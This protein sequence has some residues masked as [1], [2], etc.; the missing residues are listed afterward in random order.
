MGLAKYQ[1]DFKLFLEGVKIDVWEGASLQTMV[2]NGSSAEFSI[3]DDGTLFSSFVPGLRVAFFM[4]RQPYMPDFKDEDD[5]VL[6]FEGECQRISRRSAQG[7]GGKV[8]VFSCN[9]WSFYSRQANYYLYDVVS[10][11]AAKPDAGRR[12]IEADS[13]IGTESK[14]ETPGAVVSRTSQRAQEGAKQI[15]SNNLTREL[16]T[17]AGYRRSLFKLLTRNGKPVKDIFSKRGSGTQ[18]ELTGVEEMLETFMYYFAY[19]GDPSEGGIISGTGEDQRIYRNIFE[20]IRMRKKVFSVSDGQVGNIAAGRAYTNKQEAAKGDNWAQFALENFFHSVGHHGSFFDL[21]GYFLQEG[22]YLFVENLGPPPTSLNGE[23]GINILTFKPDMFFIAPPQCNVI[24][25]MDIVAVQ[26]SRNYGAEPTFGGYLL[27][28]YKSIPEQVGG[29]VE[30]IGNLQYNRSRAIEYGEIDNQV[31]RIRVSVNAS[32]DP[33]IE[34]LRGVNPFYRDFS[35]LMDHFHY[36][37]GESVKS[38]NAFREG[39]SDLPTDL[40]LFERKLEREFYDRIFSAR[41]FSAN[42]QFSPFLLAGHPCLVI[43][44][45]YNTTGTI[46]SI[47]HNIGARSVSTSISVGYSR[48]SAF[49]DESD[50]NIADAPDINFDFYND[51]YKGAELDSTY[52]DFFGTETA[53]GITGSVNSKANDIYKEVKKLAKTFKEDYDSLEDGQK[54]RYVDDVRRRSFA[55]EEYYFRQVM[56]AEGALEES[57]QTTV[58]RAFPIDQMNDSNSFP[59]VAERQT[60]ILQYVAN[61]KERGRLKK[62][63]D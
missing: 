23:R 3:P 46:E 13:S 47:V 50:S 56:G 42:L 36:L 60:P 5:F 33:R 2:N 41:N 54:Q 48:T 38:F 18:K 9:G 61:I 22:I 14:R 19:L 4:R 32:S 34:K 11:T 51:K 21:V 12:A 28:R 31:G 8:I 30:N 40:S 49:D 26:N 1:Q 62:G 45:D 58:Y 29:R 6:L 39:G 17:E 35:P 16:A 37:P 53:G 15:V 57:G 20:S 52:R 63:R 59:F 27:P 44:D 43:E 10:K 25:P 55:G 24:F 7:G